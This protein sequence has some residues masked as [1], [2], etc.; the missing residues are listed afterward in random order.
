MTR[1][2]ASRDDVLPPGD[3]LR[4]GGTSSPRS[5]DSKRHGWIVQVSALV[6]LV[7]AIVSTVYF[8][9][10]WRSCEYE[11][12]SAGCAVLPTDAT[13]MTVAAAVT[14]IALTVLISAFRSKDR[15]AAP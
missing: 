7:G 2:P 1:R 13:V 14:A 3:E 6:A 12:I 15:S 9:Q 8:F 5:M 11:D 4:G 10:P